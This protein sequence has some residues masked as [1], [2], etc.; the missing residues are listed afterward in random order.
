MFSQ[1]LRFTFWRI[2]LIIT[3]LL[4]WIALH[5]AFI[6]AESLG[7]SP[8]ASKTWLILLSS[9]I[10]TGSISLLLAGLSFYRAG[11]IFEKYLHFFEPGTYYSSLS[12][13]KLWLTWLLF[14]IILTTYPL[15][16]FHPYYGELLNKQDGLRLFLFWV[17]ALAGTQAFRL[18]A[19]RLSETQA[20]LVTLILQTSLLRIALYLPDISAY[21]FSMGW[22]ETSRFYYPALFYS[23]PIFGKSLPWP[24]LHPTLH[25]VLLPP[26]L[27]HAPLWFHRLWQVLIR[28]LLVG[29]I[30]PA[31]ISRV[32]ISSRK[33]RWI[34]GT[35]VFLILF[36]L[37][38]YLHLAVPVFIILWSF[39]IHNNRRTWLWLAVASIWAG[40]SR[41]NLYPVPAMLAAALYFLETPAHKIGWRTLIKPIL[42]FSAGSSMAFIAMQM[43]IALSGIGEAGNFFT[44][45]SSPKLWDR[46]WPNAAYPLGVLPGIVLFSLPIWLAIGVNAF[47]IGWARMS[48]LAAE[49]VILFIGGI[50]VSMKIGGGADI[51]NMDGYAVLLVII[52]VYMVFE[53]KPSGAVSMGETQVLTK[54]AK[55]QEALLHWIPV[56][57]LV[58]I[59][60]WFGVQVKVGFWNYD[61]KTVTNTLAALQQQVDRVNARGGEILFITQRH[62]IS[63]HMIKGVRLIPEYE[64]EELMEMA[65]SKN[66]TFLEQF[67]NDIENHRF[68]AIII[69]PLRINY[70]SD[71][72]AMGVENN[73]WTR[74]VIKPVL[75]NYQAK[76]VFAEDRIA[77]YVPQ[78]AGDQK[79]P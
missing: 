32:N 64:R 11:S 17:I 23:Q 77:I 53:P 55:K 50:I 49:L 21:P 76:A 62:L 43:Y 75:C 2:V 60:A 61:K 15:L 52:C 78:Q 58:L 42:W 67:N 65:M 71:K 35:W 16:I 40:L 14:F 20:L 37:P 6:L 31:L 25:F 44:S 24:I 38:L 13:W 41:I 46:L 79:C 70:V 73:A 1:P 45:L 30:A 22:S 48:L 51:H 28:F 54:P 12:G 36:T 18:G 9:I 19:P 69:D 8:L 66:E 7:I 26:Y 74:H 4:A 59:P 47:K 39:S 68:A 33:A 72:E 5:D 29:L 34:V 56:F 63:M 3:S 57:L 10:L 27:I